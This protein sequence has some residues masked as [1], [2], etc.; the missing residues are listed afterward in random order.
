M[1][2]NLQERQQKRAAEIK[3][4]GPAKNAAEATKQMLDRKVW[5]TKLTLVLSF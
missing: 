1:N 5:F 2:Y 4:A 3:N